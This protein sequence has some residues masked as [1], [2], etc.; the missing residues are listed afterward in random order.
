MTTS[1]TAAVIH[2]PGGEFSFETVELDPPRKDEIL[3]RIEASGV[4]HTDMVAQS[5]TPLPAVLGH[6]GAG[7]VEDVGPGV[8]R[9]KRGDHVVISYPWCGACPNCLEGR[10]YVC[11]H[12]NQLCFS[13]A[14]LDGSKPIAMNGEAISSAF[15]QQSSF[16]THSITLERDVIPIEG[17]HLSEMLAAIPCGVQTGAGAVLNTFKAGPKDS[18]VVFGAGAVGLSAIM[19]GTLSGVSPIIAVDIVEG[20]LNLALE[21]G[22]THALNPEQEDILDRIGEIAKA[23]IKFS[24]ET[25]GNEQAFNNAIEC[26]AMGGKCGIVTYPHSFKT[27]F[28]PHELLIHGNSL[29]GILQGSS[30]PGT[31][32]PRLLDLNRHGKFPYERLIKNYDF[33]DINKA[34]EDSKAGLAIKPVLKMS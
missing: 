8:H 6:E 2:K 9:V 13:G 32:L 28:S 19:A 23:G 14:R 3:V 17:D 22:A 1:A 15:F 21:L 10:A 24:L 27:P 30:I 12:V 18:L 11:E 20:R 7:I 33:S 31:F 4:C 25:T 5:I 34:F 26:L 29:I 16:A